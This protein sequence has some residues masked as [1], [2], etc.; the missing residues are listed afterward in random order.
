MTIAERERELEREKL[1]LR[2]AQREQEEKIFYDN[3]RQDEGYVARD[4][5]NGYSDAEEDARAQMSA[6]S[7]P[8]QMWQPSFY[9]GEEGW[10]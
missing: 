5:G 6:T 4:G 9:G 2:R 1:Q 8:S 10:D 3:G 7:Y